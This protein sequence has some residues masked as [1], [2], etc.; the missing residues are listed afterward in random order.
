MDL[1]YL[2]GQRP[3]DTLRFD[4]SHIR[5]GELWVIQGKRG[6]KLRISVVGELG[7]VIKRIQAR[8]VGYRVASS[9]LVVNEKGERMGADALRFR[10][11]AARE[12]A[13]IEKG[14]FQFRDLRAKAGTDKTELSGDIRAA[15]KQLGHQSITMTEHYV[16]ERKGDKVGPTR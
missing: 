12:A 9:A 1:A 3:A 8:K 5:D 11:D 4:E 7:E 14:L 10:F 16:R 13:G 2:T 6:K 15:Q